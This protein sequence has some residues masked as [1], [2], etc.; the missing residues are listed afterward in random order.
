MLES[1]SCRTNFHEECKGCYCICHSRITERSTQSEAL[2]TESEALS[3]E[4]AERSG[5]VFYQSRCLACKAT[6]DNCLFTPSQIAKGPR[7]R[8]CRKCVAEYKE[9]LK[10]P[11]SKESFEHSFEA[12]HQ[13]HK[14]HPWKPRWDGPTG[15]GGI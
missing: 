4:V 1:E 8:M 10:A 15:T 6:K 11:R 12:I 3:T 2:S 5:E 7:C 14:R 9:R 13:Q